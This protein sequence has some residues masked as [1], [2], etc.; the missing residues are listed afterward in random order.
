MLP[1]G[2]RPGLEEIEPRLLY[3]ADAA[4]LLGGLP[5]AD[6][7]QVASTSTA[8]AAAP[9]A[10]SGAR[11]LLVDR[12]AEDW[13]R[14]LAEAQ[15]L[16]PSRPLQLRWVEPD[17]D[18]VALRTAAADGGQAALVA[19]WTDAAGRAWL[20]RSALEVAPPEP[21]AAQ[22]AAAPVEAQVEAQVEAGPAEDWTLNARRELVVIDGR[23]EG[24]GALA[25]RWWLDEDATRTLEVVVTD[26]S[27]DGL[28]QVGELLAARE[29]L[30][31]LHLVGHGTAGQFS[32][33]GDAIDAGTLA[34]H[35][36]AL[37]AWGQALAENGDL[38][39]YGCDTGAGSQGE[40]LLEA[41]QA[42]TW[43]PAPMP[44]A[45]APPAPTGTWRPHAAP[46]RRR[47]PRRRPK[48][49]RA[50]KGGWR[51]T[52]SPTS[53]TTRSRSSRCVRRS[54]RPTPVQVPTPSPSPTSA[55]R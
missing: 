40:A 19:A 27:R 41:L 10:D 44:P 23:I 3:S 37:R 34:R 42:L 13:D 45:A 39:L 7:R 31:A 28:T 43:R 20:G 36:A 26:P 33:G 5:V 18:G 21:V 6:V 50:G 14:L 24:A 1:S 29:G 55:C 32:F 12:R 52:P 16:D 8:A 51:A 35:E 25:A 38:L 47:C 9:L 2:P 53:P 48:P 54:I 22:V 30:S 46:S 15:A 17:E 49:W 4:L 11:W